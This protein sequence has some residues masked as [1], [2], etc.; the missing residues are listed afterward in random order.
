MD[1]R[2]FSP[3]PWL[4]EAMNRHIISAFVIIL[5]SLQ[6]NRLGTFQPLP[7]HHE[8]SLFLAKV[9]QIGLSLY[10]LSFLMTLFEKYIF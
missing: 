5:P 9:R 7:N 2:T 1:E 4:Y 3:V 8:L 10:L 6:M